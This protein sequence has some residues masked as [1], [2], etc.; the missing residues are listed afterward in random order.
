MPGL[1]WSMLV[2]A[3]LTLG[4][5]GGAFAETPQIAPARGPILV[6]GS[7]GFAGDADDVED[8][9]RAA[10]GVACPRTDAC[11]VVFDE[12]AEARMIELGPDGAVVARPEP[13][14][15]AAGG[16]VDAEGAATDGAMIYVVGSHAMK[17]S[18]CAANPASRVV[19]RAPVAADGR[20]QLPFEART[21]SSLLEA[22]QLGGAANPLAG[23]LGKCLGAEG[24]IDIEGVAIFDGR[25]WFGLR[26]PT[27]GAQVGILSVEADAFFADGDPAPRLDWVGASD[28]RGLRDLTADGAGGLLLLVGPDD[29]PENAD[30]G[31][32]LLRWDGESA[33]ASPLAELDLSK[34][35]RRTDLDGCD[36]AKKVLD[37]KP[38]AIHVQGDSVMVL[39][40]GLCD[41][42]LSW[43]NL[44]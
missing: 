41:G 25:L 1:A 36:D 16:E 23:S 21:L 6:E 27:Q 5:A 42:G 8:L 29:R 15:L 30:A 44:P 32:A 3:G 14:A 18:S 26:G 9:R 10:S 40:D 13:L 20:L 11:L 28:R 38:E 37:R 35:D 33:E 43:F 2:G 24:G 19:L 22:E 4:S 7:F 31:W 34:I 39:S 12:G 17:R